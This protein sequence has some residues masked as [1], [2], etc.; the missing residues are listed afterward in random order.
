MPYT[1]GMPSYI[2][3][4]FFFFFFFCMLYSYNSLN[5]AYQKLGH[6]LCRWR[7]D[8]LASEMFLT[9]MILVKFDQ[10]VIL[11]KFSEVVI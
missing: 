6:W 7:I 2:C 10:P 9:V 1:S 11:I 8:Q 5:V 3:E 4:V